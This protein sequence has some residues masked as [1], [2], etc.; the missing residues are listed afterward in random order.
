MWGS[1]RP[2][3]TRRRGTRC[4]RWRFHQL[5]VRASERLPWNWQQRLENVAITVEES[6]A[7]DVRQEGGALGLYQGTPRGERGTWYTL[8]LPDKISVYRRPLLQACHSRREL[9]REVELTL[10]HEIGH[11]F[12]MSDEELPF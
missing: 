6:P 9:Q 5:V 11:Y 7:D 3:P 4:T 1:R 2:R 12:G 10:L 8:V